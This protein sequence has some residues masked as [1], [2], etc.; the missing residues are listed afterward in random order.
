MISRIGTYLLVLLMLGLGVWSFRLWMG[1]RII[2]ANPSVESYVKALRWN[3]S[4]DDYHAV[5]GISYRDL[6]DGQDLEA[7]VREL[8]TAVEIRPSV[9]IYHQSLAMAYEMKGEFNEA[10]D[11]FREA[12][13]LAPHNANL[14]W[15]V[16]NFYMRRQNIPETVNQ[17][18]AAV[19]LDPGNMTFA[20][21]RLAAL[22]V[23]LEDISKEL[24]PQRRQ[25]LLRFLSFVLGHR[26][27]D[28]ERIM[29][30]SWETWQRWEQASPDAS[31]NIRNL[32]GF[33]DYLIREGELEKA[34]YVWEVGLQEAGIR[35]ESGSQVRKFASSVHR[36]AGSRFKNYRGLG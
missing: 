10:E 28:P 4:S 34:R 27:D 14:Q 16:A 18:R 21:N 3:P 20:A 31:F 5:L 15:Q 11:S 32:F 29:N 13:Q 19:E 12:L 35:T 36:F 23:T 2:E 25:D 6:V 9:W 30:L 1:E 22:G 26:K 17:F 24:V 8:K 7:A 33:I